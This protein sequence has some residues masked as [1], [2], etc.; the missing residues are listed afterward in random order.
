MMNKPITMRDIASIAGTS[1]STVSKALN[2]S[3]EIPEGTRQRIKK[4]ASEH[5]Y[6]PNQIARSLRTESNHVVGMIVPDCSNLYYAR[7]LRGAQDV[8]HEAGFSIV[9]GN[10]GENASSEREQITAMVSLRVAGIIATPVCEQSYL[11][12]PVPLVFVSRCDGHFKELFSYTITNDFKGA[13]L[14]VEYL[15]K[16]GKRDVYFLSG[17]KNISIATERKRGYVAAHRAVSAECDESK[18]LYGYLSMEDG[19]RAFEQIHRENPNPKGFFCSSDNIAIGV[20]AGAREHHLEIPREIGIVGYD[21]IEMLKFLDFPLTT[22]RQARYQI[23]A[24]GAGLLMDKLH[25]SHVYHQVNQIIMEP[26]LII[27]ST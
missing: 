4:I 7:L 18:I 24:Q 25:H 3:S 17:P 13:F 12:I 19:Y 16:Q 14:A 2:D 26:E 22:I 11:S 9:V 6:T 20:L 15:L 8:L 5:G 10:T 23:G 21:D 1:L 27:R